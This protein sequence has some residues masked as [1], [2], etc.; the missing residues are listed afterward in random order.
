MNVLDID[1]STTNLSTLHTKLA[2]LTECYGLTSIALEQFNVLLKSCPEKG[3]DTENEPNFDIVIS[4]SKIVR[5]YK[6]SDEWKDLNKVIKA[7]INNVNKQKNALQKLATKMPQ[8][9]DLLEN[10][11][12]VI[13]QS[14]IDVAN[15]CKTN[16]ENIIED[17]DTVLQ[18]YQFKFKIPIHDCNPR[19]PILRTLIDL[20]TYLKSINSEIEKLD[21]DKKMD[22]ESGSLDANSL[23]EQTEDSIAT[24][25]LIIQS[26]YKKH[27]PKDTTESTEVLNA[28]DE[29]IKSDTKEESKDIVEDKHLKEHLQEKLSNDSKMLQLELLMDKIRHVL[30]N[31]VQYLLDGKDVDDVRSVMMRLVPIL[32]QTVLFVQYFITQKVAVHR[33]SCKML[34]VLLKIFTDLAS[35]GFCKPSDMDMEEGEGEGGPG[36]LSGGMGLGDG[37]GQK[38]VSDRIENQDQLDD[39]QRPG[40]EKKE[41]NRD[42]KE[43]EKG[44][45]MTDDFDS[46]LQDLEKKEGDQ[47]EQE[48]DEDDA[49]KQMGDTDNAAEKLDQQIWGSEDEEDLEEQEQKTD[50]EEKGK[51]ESTGEKELAAK[52][53]EQ[54]QGADDGAEGQDKKKKKDINEMEEPEVDD[55]HVDPY[56]GNQQQMPEPEDFELPENMDVDGEDPDDG[57][58]GETETE[59]PFDIDVMKEN[60][61]DEDEKDENKDNGV[62]DNKAGLEVSSDEEEGENNAD[63]DDGNEKD[64]E[65]ESESLEPEKPDAEEDAQ[66]QDP[67]GGDITKPDETEQPEETA[68]PDNPEVGEN[69]DK[70]ELPKN[71]DKLEEEDEVEQKNQNSNP[72]ANPSNNDPTAEDKA[73]NADMD[74]GTDDN[75]ETNADQKKDEEA[76]ATEQSQEQVGEEKQSMGRSELDKSE[77]GHQGEKQAANRANSSQDKQ[78]RRENKPADTDQERT[79]GDINEKKRKQAQTLNVEKDN[80]ADDGV[81]NDDEA[82][83]EADAYQHVK[84]A[85]AD[86]LQAVDAATKE[87]ADQQPTL[88]QEDDEDADKLKE[89][90]QVAMDVDDDDIEVQ[91][92]EEL[93]PEKMKEAADKDKEKSGNKKDGGEEPTGETGIEVEGENIVTAH[94]PRGTETSYHTRLEETPMDTE[95]MSLDTYMSVRNWL[96]QPVHSAHARAGV[97][98]TLWRDS[99]TAARALCEKL[100][101]VLEPTGRSRRAGDFRTGRAINMRRVI[102]YIASHFRKDRIWLRRTKPAKREYKIA[103]AVDDSSSMS[104]NRSKELAFESLALVSQALNLLESG[105]LAVLSFG[106]KPNLLHPFTEQFTEH[107]GSKIL[108]QLRFEQTKTRIAQLLDFS[109]VMFEEQSIRSDAVNAKLLVIVSDGRGIFSEGETKVLQAVRRA[110]Q[111]GIFLVY[112]I[113]DNPDNKDSIMDIRRPLLDPV[114]NTLTG[115]VS[116]LDTF[117]FPFYLILRDMSALPTV[118]GDA[119]RQWFE[120]AANTS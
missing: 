107:S 117:P 62:K 87:Q 84:Q 75:V 115:F 48:D 100:R 55:D 99:S 3:V 64:N 6:N 15:D 59:N 95:D 57:K 28:I 14:H 11:V 78:N 82:E 80:E 116:Y 22:V 67:E 19:H 70:E 42:C 43:E 72:Q 46:H 16:L 103:I 20:S 110:R 92:A 47:S 9:T 109:T 98:S 5:C 88:Q 26:I 34:S 30:L 102:P 113:I 76:A 32:E 36:K 66:E 56:H 60:I 90:E 101:L 35:K 2:I 8:E 25:L 27:L 89:D 105:D 63:Q 120:L 83:K 58:D 119:L 4:D 23:I 21:S 37:E 39:A 31:Y 10:S 53:K 40:E 18:D 17:I 79:L 61:V 97:W 12:L 24:M 71:T 118:L 7:L 13:S 81:E 104:D 51:G 73:E 49:D 94:V 74:R 68:E 86:D 93:K 29:I 45:N 50:K 96:S 33:V 111:Q 1:D 54:E 91:K 112:V 41:E 52:D 114:A 65:N 44:V 77:K 69:E 108:E 38:D 85:K 106:E